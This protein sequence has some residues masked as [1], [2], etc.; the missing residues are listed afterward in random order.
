LGDAFLMLL[1]LLD[2]LRAQFLNDIDNQILA[3]NQLIVI[4]LSG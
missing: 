3:S 1:L 4:I 2:G